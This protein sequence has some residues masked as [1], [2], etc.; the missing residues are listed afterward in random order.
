MSDAPV[1]TPE[2]SRAP[3]KQTRPHY[4]P[5]LSSQMSVQSSTQESVEVVKSPSMCTVLSMPT[6]VIT[7]EGTVPSQE[8]RQRFLTQ[9]TQQQVCTDLVF[10]VHTYLTYIYL[11]TISIKEGMD[12]KN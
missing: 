10:L 9:E 2:T 4:I 8:Q 1:D 12:N 6:S 5:T 7:K 3:A 11:C